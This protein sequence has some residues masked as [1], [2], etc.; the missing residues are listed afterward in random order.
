MSKFLCMD[1]GI[2]ETMDGDVLYR[3]LME[4]VGDERWNE[5]IEENK[6]WIFKTQ[7]VISSFINRRRRQ[8]LVHSYIY[9]V[10]DDN[11]IDDCTWSK[12]AEQLV[13]ITD[14]FPHIAK[15]C[16]F[17]DVFEYFD[18]STGAFWDWSSTYMLGII[19]TAEWLMTKGEY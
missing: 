4:F 6:P 2:C 15:Q 12:W 1:G 7:S 16:D 5:R 9:Y 11:L 8:I 19:S 3:K 10:R 17:S 18:G 14:A 13:D